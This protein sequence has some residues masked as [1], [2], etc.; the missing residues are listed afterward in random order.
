MAVSKQTEEQFVKGIHLKA[1][2]EQAKAVDPKLWDAMKGIQEHYS[3]YSKH[4]EA[5]TQR[6]VL[7]IVLW[8]IKRQ[9]EF[10]RSDLGSKM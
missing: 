6:T 10:I 4:C 2:Y 8:E 5:I 3:E 9:R 1:A 7:D